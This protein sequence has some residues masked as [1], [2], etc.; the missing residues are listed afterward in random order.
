MRGFFV[1]RGLFSRA[2]RA[3]GG[4]EGGGVGGDK[5]LQPTVHKHNI[6]LTAGIPHNR[7]QDQLTLDPELW[8]FA[9]SKSL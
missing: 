9:K 4:R 5:R 3:G 8:W 7:I 6:R 1:C 2:R